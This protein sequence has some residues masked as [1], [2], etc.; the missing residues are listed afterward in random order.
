MIYFIYLSSFFTHY[1]RSINTFKFA[2]DVNR[3]LKTR[4]IFHS[5]STLIRFLNY[6][7][8]C[9]DHSLHDL[10]S[11]ININEII[12]AK[13]I[14]KYVMIIFCIISIKLA[15]ARRVNYVI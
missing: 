11:S 12:N 7:K 15:N 2:N 10:R 4:L 14:N 13:R 3:D 9:N 1:A 8:K 5:L 6:Y